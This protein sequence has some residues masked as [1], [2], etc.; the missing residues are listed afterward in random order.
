VPVSIRVRGVR[1]GGRGRCAVLLG[2]PVLHEGVDS[3]SGAE[4][5][6]GERPERRVV[7]DAA[8]EPGPLTQNAGDVDTASVHQHRRRRQHTR[9]DRRCGDGNAY[10]EHSSS[11]D[12]PRREQIGCAPSQLIQ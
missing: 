1:A 10:R 11:V 2:G 12:V 5:P 9:V 8:R 3:G 4:A 7:P 6:L